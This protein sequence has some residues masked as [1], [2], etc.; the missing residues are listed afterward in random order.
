MKRM[1]ELDELNK[2]QT[3]LV[4]DTEAYAM[5]VKVLHKGFTQWH[6]RSPARCSMRRGCP[7]KQ[8]I[9]IAGQ[10]IAALSDASGGTVLEGEKFVWVSRSRIL[11]SSKSKPDAKPL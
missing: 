5:P 6:F 8:G 7:R 3:S 10:T 4:G 2:V 1:I 9:Q 11:G